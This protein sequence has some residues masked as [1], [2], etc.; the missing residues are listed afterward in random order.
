M[1]ANGSVNQGPPESKGTPVGS[2]WRGVWLSGPVGVA[3]ALAA[4][5]AGLGVPLAFALGVAV[6]VGLA[7]FD[8]SKGSR[9]VHD[10]AFETARAEELTRM[11]HLLEETDVV[12]WEF[13]PEEA[14]FVYVSPQVRRFGYDLA[15]WYR[16]GFFWEILHSEDC[17]ST[18]H[19]C[20]LSTEKGLDHE[21]V[22][23]MYCADGSVV[24]IRDLVKVLQR[25]GKGPLLRGVFV[26]MTAQKEAEAEIERI[27]Q[28]ARIEAE[29][30]ELA[31]AGGSIGIWDWNPQSGDLIV[32][33]C[34]IDISGLTRDA[35]QG[36][37]DD[38]A[39]AVHEEDL[40]GALAAVEAHFAGENT[41][42]ESTFRKRRPDGEIRWI[43][44]RGKALEFDEAGNPTRMVGIEI[45]QTAEIEARLET[46]RLRDAAEAANRSK[47]EFLANMSHEIRTPLTAILGY[48]DLML[49]GQEELDDEE[50]TREMLGTIHQSGSHLISLIN[51]ILDLSKIEADRIQLEETEV[52]LAA[53]ILDVVGMIRPRTVEK[54]VSLRVTIE[55]DV[56]SHVLC[57]EVRM[58]QILVNILGNAAKFTDIGT[59]ELRMRAD[60]DS[61]RLVFEV[62]DT[63]HG[64]TAD[65]AGRL[66]RQF[67]QGDS[68]V[69]RRFGGSGLGLVI[70]RRLAALMGG[71][72]RLEQTELGVGSTFVVEL[73]CRAAEGAGRLSGSDLSSENARPLVV[74]D[75]S[76]KLEARVLLVE[77]G[78]V[79]QR[80]IASILRG[81]GATVDIASHGVEAL[82]M[83]AA[84]PDGDAAY[85]IILTD[86]QM[87][88][89]D[90]YTLAA[91][92]RRRGRK[93]PII[94]LT[95]HAMA[96]D[97]ARCI[98]A[99]CDDYATKPI[100]RLALIETCARWLRVSSSEQAA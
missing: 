53:L 29:R 57:D 34:W 17:E 68:S 84:H 70:S 79:N 51:D 96:E 10:A 67:V 71:D 1:Q 69:T 41:F 33:D 52:D 83:I 15:E 85:Q 2:R 26:D 90:G 77:D 98:E 19:S 47:S 46:E 23:R 58:R 45:D 72:V 66:F 48:A 20:Q 100:D 5:D 65:Q 81:A 22:Y 80:L 91:D 28:A 63:G 95:A 89:M 13:E 7:A 86:M 93:T 3:I 9:S 40:P 16:E 25:P 27:S 78:V 73:G 18:Q 76:A 24:W 60:A 62:E 11:R 50:R 74:T 37:T 54:A 59:V 87:P 14:R 35:L 30:F 99:G 92:L 12:T 44:S 6:S 36:N 4:M 39:N 42:Y 75:P 97:R 49:S 8:K 64:M 21:L 88:V 55:G 82:E 31:F 61:G 43:L 38:W 94:A 32:N 56:P